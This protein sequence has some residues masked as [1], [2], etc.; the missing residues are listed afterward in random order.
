MYG[1]IHCCIF[2]QHVYSR[3]LSQPIWI[4]IIHTEIENGINTNSIY[5]DNIAM[6][7]K[8]ATILHYHFTSNSSGSHCLPP[9]KDAID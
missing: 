9:C 5:N 4:A 8:C 1:L 3:I 2:F 7:I 6:A